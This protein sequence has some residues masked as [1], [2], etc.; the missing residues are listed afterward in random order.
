MIKYRQ[1]TCFSAVSRC[2]LEPN[3]VLLVFRT[4][5]WFQSPETAW[6]VPSV[7]VIAHRRALVVA[8]KQVF[9]VVPTSHNVPKLRLCVV[10]ESFQN[11]VVTLLNRAI[12]NILHRL[13]EGQSSSVRLAC[14]LLEMLGK[15]VF[16]INVV[17]APEPHTEHPAKQVLG[18]SAPNE[19]CVSKHTWTLLFVEVS[20]LKHRRVGIIVPYPAAATSCA[21]LQRSRPK[22]ANKSFR[23]NDCLTLWRVRT[24]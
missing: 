24:Y 8:D 22:P 1:T 9:L 4:T 12:S 23:S 21:A 20:V 11:H 13:N 14:L 2:L 15:R 6:P 18:Q 17:S 5:I 7:V 19:G 16:V 10:A 3:Q